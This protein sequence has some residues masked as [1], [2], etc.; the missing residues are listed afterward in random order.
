[1]QPSSFFNKL[2]VKGGIILSRSLSRAL[3]I[4]ELF[5]T[6][7]AEWG[8]S[9]IS[10]ELDLPKSTVHGLIKTLENHQFIEATEHNRYRL[11]IK[12]Y[13]LGLTYQGTAKLSIIAEPLIKML[14]L[15]YQQS[16]HIAIYAGKMAV[17]IIGNKSGTSQIIFP[18][19]GT[20]IAA[21]CTGVGKVLLAF[22]SENYINEY[23][24]TEKLISYTKNTIIDKKALKEELINIKEQGYAIDREEAVMGIGCVAAPIFSFSRDIMAA[25]SVSGTVEKILA[26][27]R[28]ATCVF[29]VRNAAKSISESLGYKA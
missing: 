8:I 6:E 20:G 9:E 15:K 7:E 19:I 4:L 1:M 29:D 28:L 5:S 25:I 23:L 21:Y 11:G 22:Q 14:A 27:D 2:L 24:Q 17:F 18:R 10:Q 13:E 12:L 3:S 16:V 26:E